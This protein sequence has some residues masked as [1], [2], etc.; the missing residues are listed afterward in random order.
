MPTPLN[1]PKAPALDADDAPEPPPRG[2]K[3]MAIFRWLLVVLAAVAAIG[4]WT[5]YV[6]DQPSHGGTAAAPAAKVKYQCP[7]HPQ[8]VSDEPG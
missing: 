8:I 1:D 7:M 3:A 2:V 5:A 4:T 6:R